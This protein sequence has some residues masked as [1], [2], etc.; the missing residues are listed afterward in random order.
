MAFGIDTLVEHCSIFKFVLAIKM[1]RLMCLGP[2]RCGADAPIQ[3]ML[4][5]VMAGAWVY[6]HILASDRVGALA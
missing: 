2:W 4:S 1:T 6:T 3:G 5:Y